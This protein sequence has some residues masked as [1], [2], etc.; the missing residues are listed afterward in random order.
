M[1]VALP[2]APVEPGEFTAAHPGER[3]EVQCL[4]KPQVHGAGQVAAKLRSGP[5]LW[6]TAFARLR[7]WCLGD[8]SNICADEVAA[9]RIS[10]RGADHDVDVV[11]GLVGKFATAA[12]PVLE[13]FAIEVVDVFDAQRSHRDVAD[14]W[15]DVV[16]DHP[17]VTMRCTRAELRA[18]SWH[19]LLR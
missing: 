16:V 15:V 4:V 18:T 14:T 3:G 13:E 2:V 8:E 17:L 1:G 9:G 19:P 5:C 6:P 12:A 11:D 7:S 10:E